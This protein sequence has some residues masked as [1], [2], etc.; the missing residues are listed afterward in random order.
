MQLIRIFAAALV[1]A[2]APAIAR[3]DGAL[4]ARG[5]YY[6]EKATRVIQPMLDGT[7]DAG[8]RGTVDGHFLVDAITSA[9]GA[10]GAAGSAFT[11]NRY[12]AG[13]SYAHQRD[14]IR[15]AISARY[16]TE[17][18]YKSLF[19]GARADLELAEKNTILGFGGGA[20]KDDLSNA[21]AQGDFVELIEGS[22]NTLLGSLSATQLLSPDAVVS[23]TYDYARLEGTQHNLYRTVITDTGL[24]PEVHPDLRG[25]H[26]IAAS[27]RW[28]ATGTRT[29]FIG[30]YRYYWDTWKV[31]A[32]TPELRVV[33]EAGDSVEVGVRYRFHSQD[34][35]FF[36]A[37][38][39]S[40]PLLEMPWRS[41][42]IKLS[43]FTSHTY[44]AK[45]AFLGD[46]FGL[47]GRWG[48][49]RVEL[50]IQYV[51][52]NNRFGNA[53][54]AQAAFTVPLTY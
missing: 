9:S 15:G 5:A 20:G 6:K 30:A 18:D 34:G 50:L 40:G 8:E 22:M 24:V 33:Q 37:P 54:V 53:I 48:G 36:Y 23:V 12:E 2:G 25:R 1:F 47:E 28:F 31:H 13:V 19:V 46:V 45:L 51:D 17:P 14:I 7:F 29:A 35:A 27:G 26:A 38:R 10:A 49:S 11:E 52:Q 42:D 16:S 41:D 4:T 44:E 43:D 21:G 39:Y 32:H 3:G